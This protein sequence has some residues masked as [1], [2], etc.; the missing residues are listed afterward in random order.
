MYILCSY[1]SLGIF[2]SKISRNSLSTDVVL[3]IQLCCQIPHM[4]RT[5]RM[6]K[7]NTPQ[8]GFRVPDRALTIWNMEQN[9]GKI[10]TTVIKL[11]Q[12]VVTIVLDYFNVRRA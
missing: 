9:N 6:R 10:K 12:M 2:N 4:R 8:I 1:Y 5:L 3:S 7:T 11:V